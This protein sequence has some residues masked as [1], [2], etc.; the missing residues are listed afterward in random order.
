MP[1]QPVRSPSRLA[2]LRHAIRGL[3]VLLSQPNARI[4]CVA[5]LVAVALGWQLSISP[6]EWLSVVLSIAL[7]ISAEALNTA[8]E[9]A[10]DL[11]SPQWQP[12]ARDAKD[13]AAAAVF[14]SSVG[15]A[16]VGWLVFSPHI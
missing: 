6:A 3:R 11:V 10:V 12:L 5:A 7:V 15:A 9:H 13:V 4:Q 8:L 2:S 1:Q 14:I 16:V